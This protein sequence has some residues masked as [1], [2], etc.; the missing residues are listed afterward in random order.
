MSAADVV[1]LWWCRSLNMCSFVCRSRRCCRAEMETEN[2]GTAENRRVKLAIW[3]GDSARSLETLEEE[4]TDEGEDE[5]RAGTLKKNSEGTPCCSGCYVTL[6][7]AYWWQNNSREDGGGWKHHHRGRSYCRITPTPHAAP[8]LNATGLHEKT[9]RSPSTGPC[10]VCGTLQWAQAQNIV[11][12][13]GEELTGEE[14]CG[15]I[16]WLRD[17]FTSV[18]GPQRLS[19]TFTSATNR[20]MAPTVLLLS[21]FTHTKK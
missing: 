12:H 11:E 5:R 13:T 6:P 4:Q 2:G 9:C 21:V 7:P 1:Q 3:W 19:L 18:S 15:K 20:K 10:S 8:S 14:Q 16:W 17:P